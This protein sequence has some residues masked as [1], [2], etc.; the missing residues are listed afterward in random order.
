MTKK[1]LVAI[2][3]SLMIENAGEKN[4]LIRIADRLNEQGIKTPQGKD[5]TP[6]NLW[7]FKSI[8]S[9]PLNLALMEMLAEFDSSEIRRI[10]APKHRLE[11]PERL[12]RRT[13][14][15]FGR[16]ERELEAP[17]RGGLKSVAQRYGW[18][19]VA[20]TDSELLERVEQRLQNGDQSVSQL[21]EN[22]LKEWLEGQD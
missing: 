14:Q 4:F 11:I 12:L 1:E 13:N 6:Q 2:I 9:D 19:P 15:G 7:N 22:L 8:N 18:I 20:I 10:M 17:L 5:W 3:A 16:V 21:I